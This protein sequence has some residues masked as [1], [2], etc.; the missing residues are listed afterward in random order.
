MGASIAVILANIRSIQQ[1]R[2][3]IGSLKL[4]LR[5]ALNATVES[6]IEEKES[7]VKNVRIGSKQNAQILMI[8]ITLRRRKWCDIALISRKLGN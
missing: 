4:I 8:N 1:N 3:S 2:L 5:P 7:N 6:L